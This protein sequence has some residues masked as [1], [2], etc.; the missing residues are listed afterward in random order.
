MAGSKE[1]GRERR[2]EREGG[3]LLNSDFHLFRTY[4][5]RIFL[6]KVHICGFVQERLL[7]FLT[8]AERHNEPSVLST[9][10]EHA[11]KKKKKN[12]AIPA[13]LKNELVASQGIWNNTPQLTIIYRTFST[14]QIRGDLLSLLQL[15]PVGLVYVEFRLDSSQERSHGQK[16]WHW[17]HHVC[18]VHWHTSHLSQCLT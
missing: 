11:Q 13:R 17:I 8:R 3:F 7:P 4:L 2:D 1:R 18:T 10:G 14:S 15:R 9:P 12:N 5:S 6:G 16:M